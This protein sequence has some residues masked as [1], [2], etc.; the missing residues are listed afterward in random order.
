MSLE[1]FHQSEPLRTKSESQVLILIF[2]EMKKKR[3]LCLVQEMIQI[4]S[5][6]FEMYFS[7]IFTL[8]LDSNSIDFIFGFI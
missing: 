3:I 1:L 7:S 6:P 8:I 2:D 4:I 5:L